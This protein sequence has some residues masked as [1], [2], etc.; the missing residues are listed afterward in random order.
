MHSDMPQSRPPS[1]EDRRVQPALISPHNHVMSPAYFWFN[2]IA[3]KSYRNGLG[4]TEKLCF[5]WIVVLNLLVAYMIG[6]AVVCATHRNHCAKFAVSVSRRIHG[7]CLRVFPR[8][9]TS[10][11]S[12]VE[13]RLVEKNRCIAQTPLT[14]FISRFSRCNTLNRSRLD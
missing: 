3:A 11:H 1:S 7:M 8:I 5:E 10:F 6:D 9:Q 12:A 14:R 4:S 2:T 13:F